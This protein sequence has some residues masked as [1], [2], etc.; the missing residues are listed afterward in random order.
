ARYVSA[1]KTCGD[2]AQWPAATSTNRPAMCLFLLDVQRS[3]QPATTCLAATAPPRDA[4]APDEASATTARACASASRATSARAARSRPFWDERKSESR[5]PSRVN[6]QRVTSPP[7]RCG[8]SASERRT[9]YAG[10]VSR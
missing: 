5:Q 3:A 4:T 6:G 7:A 8:V 10:P 2:E 1:T 9:Q